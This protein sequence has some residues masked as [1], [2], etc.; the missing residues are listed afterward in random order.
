[1]RRMP[2][3]GASHRPNTGAVRAIMLEGIAVSVG[4]AAVCL[5]IAA[6]AFVRENA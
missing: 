3:I 6:R 5:W 2:P 4:L 1:M